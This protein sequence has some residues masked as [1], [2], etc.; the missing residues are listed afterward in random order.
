MKENP[1][2]TKSDYQPTPADRL[3]KFRAQAPYHPELAYVVENLFT[4]QFNQAQGG[5]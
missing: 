2:I 4:K 1:W 5:Q 3:A